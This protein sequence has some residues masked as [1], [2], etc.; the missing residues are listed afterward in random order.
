MGE[1]TIRFQPITLSHQSGSRARPAANAVSQAGERPGTYWRRRFVVLAVGLTVFAMAAWALSDAVKV[2]AAP[3]HTGRG[4]DARAHQGPAGPGPHGAA[5]A[6]PASSP[7]PTSSGVSPS[8][9]PS[10]RSASPA[11]QTSPSPSPASRIA[12]GGEP[13]ACPRR[14]IVLSVS[15]GQAAFGGHEVPQFSLSVVSTQM[16]ACSFN[17]GSAHLALLVKDGAARIWSSA[18]CAT[19]ARRLITVLRRGV[20]EVVTLSWRRRTSSRGC[21][22]RSRPVPSG[23]YQAYATAGRLVSAPVTFRLQ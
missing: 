21:T 20:P 15:A 14:A 18:D 17:V 10:G 23:V 11:L 7:S 19:G 8:A 6:V 5:G 2:N 4:S 22:V 1:N 13:A 12:R 16:R 9:S 3:G